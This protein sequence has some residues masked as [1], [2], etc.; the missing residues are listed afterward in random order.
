MHPILA[1]GFSNEAHRVYVNEN[2][3]GQPFNFVAWYIYSEFRSVLFAVENFQPDGSAIVQMNP[4]RDYTFGRDDHLHILACSLIEIECIK[5]TVRVFA[6][7]KAFLGNNALIYQYI[8]LPPL[9]ERQDAHFCAR[10]SNASTVVPMSGDAASIYSVETR[11]SLNLAYWKILQ[12]ILKHHP[13]AEAEKSP[14]KVSKSEK[15][16]VTGVGGQVILDVEVSKFAD[17]PDSIQLSVPPQSTSVR[18]LSICFT[19]KYP[20]RALEDMIVESAADFYDHI[21][22]ISHNLDVYDFCV[23]LR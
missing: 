10:E 15:V 9:D 11:N 7:C 6:Y 4:G 2:F 8:K 20:H 21:V 17:L 1:D 14:E 18:A 16:L 5:R 23:T 3:I 12:K 19:L 22:V 13:A